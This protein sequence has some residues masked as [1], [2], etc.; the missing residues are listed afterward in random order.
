MIPPGKELISSTCEG[1]GQ[2]LLSQCLNPIT[3][4]TVCLFFFQRTKLCCFL[5]DHNS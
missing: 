5:Q 3:D 2:S 4:K 1:V